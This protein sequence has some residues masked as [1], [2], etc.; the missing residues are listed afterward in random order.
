MTGFLF[1]VLFTAF[2]LRAKFLGWESCLSADDDNVHVVTFVFVFVAAL[3]VSVIAVKKS[4]DCGRLESEYKDV[5]VN[6]RDFM[7]RTPPDKLDP[8]EFS[9]DS[10]KC[11]NPVY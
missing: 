8:V 9:Y 6:Y 4:A 3:I 1:W 11:V 7:A 5:P 2:I 10:S